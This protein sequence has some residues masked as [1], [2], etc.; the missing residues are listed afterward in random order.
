LKRNG[1]TSLGDSIS[2]HFYTPDSILKAGDLPFLFKVL[3]INQ[4]L[5]IQAHPN[6]LLAAQLH[7]RDPK[8]YPDSNHK[9]EMLIAISDTFEAMCGFRPAT[10]IVENFVNYAELVA[11][12]D[13]ENCDE[14][15][16]LCANPSLSSSGL[17]LALRKCFTALMSKPASFILTE[18]ARLKARLEANGPTRTDLESLFLRLAEQYANDVGCFAIFLLNCLT[19]R[20]GEAIFLSANIPHAYLF[21]DGVECMACSDNVVRAGLTPK[22]KDVAVLCEMLDYTMRTSEE[23]KLTS[24]RTSL[25]RE[26]DYLAEF[27]PS[28][29]EFSVQQVR[30]EVGKHVVSGQ[31]ERFL[32]PK[33][34]SGSILILNEVNR[35]ACHF[36]T[37]AGQKL[38]AKAG[39]VYF[40]DADN[41]LFL[42]VD[43]HGE[44]DDEQ[45]AADQS[46]LVLAYRAYCDIKSN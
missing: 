33:C 27:R 42:I 45:N 6:K 2:S 43:R 34:E 35:S 17:E 22:F 38:D 19:L 20:K 32:I 10:Q 39:L 12:C 15:I 7:A 31:S 29:D 18:F 46:I 16:S 25:S 5:S 41:D 28:V 4:A 3:S 36:E 44:K 1:T 26:L 14:F 9:P 37:T 30:I 21:G 13:Q 23:N 24:T 11:M 40:V 8:N